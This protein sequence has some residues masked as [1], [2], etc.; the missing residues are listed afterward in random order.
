MEENT[1]KCINPIS[2]AIGAAI[3]LVFVILMA[4]TNMYVVLGTAYAA[5]LGWLIFE[6]RQVK[7]G[8]ERPKK[9]IRMVMACWFVIA[10]TFVATFWGITALIFMFVGT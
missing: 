7:K 4:N 5:T 1:S 10:T 6:R 9:P 2:I 3:F 8:V